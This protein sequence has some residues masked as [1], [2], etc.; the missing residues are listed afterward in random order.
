[1]PNTRY[2]TAV[3]Q[4]YHA[5]WVVPKLAQIRRL[6]EL[7]NSMWPN[8]HP[9]KFV[10]VA[11]TSGKGS[12][13]RMLESG[14][15]TLGASGAFIKPHLFDYR[16]RISINGAPAEQNAIADAW[17]QVGLPANLDAATRGEAPFGFYE[18]TLLILLTLFERY[19]VAWA[20][21]EAGMGGRYDLTMALPVVACALT[22]VGRD[23][24]AAL[25]SEAWQRALDKA[26]IARPGVPLFTSERDPALL[27]IIAS[28]CADMGA[29]LHIV[30]ENDLHA[31]R[32]LI[33]EPPAESLLHAEHQQTNAALALAVLAHLLPDIDQ[34]QLAQRLLDVQLLGR[35]SEVEPGLFVDVAHNPDKVAAFAREVA[36]RFAGRGKIFV[37]SVSGERDAAAVL[38]PLIDMADAIIVT[39]A[40]YHGQPAA[41]IA[42][43]LAG[44]QPRAPVAVVADPRAALEAA[45]AQRTG[46][47][48]I[49][50]TGSTYMIE[51]ALNPDPYLRHLNGTYGWRFKKG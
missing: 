21:L 38:A 14:F 10:H 22:N 48:L 11:G 19:G 51:Q 24:E 16:E 2:L 27:E 37:V 29:P 42:A 8:G 45:K 26:G 13:S 25:G 46:D 18:N 50:L 36:G 43:A 31:L 47:Q 3:D 23:H 12:V 32:A 7:I 20:A 5:Q 34:Q 9:T 17:E 6:R 41:A 40:A 39:Q 28:V 44:L 49:F 1:M 15:A 35:M 4:I 33:G 30:D